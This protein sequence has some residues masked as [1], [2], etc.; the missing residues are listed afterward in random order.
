M[1]PPRYF[2][3]LATQ[4]SPLWDELSGGKQHLF[5]RERQKELFNMA[6]TIPNALLDGIDETKLRPWAV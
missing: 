5:T 6:V 2:H 3:L 1:L 4:V